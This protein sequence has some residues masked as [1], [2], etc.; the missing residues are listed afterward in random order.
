TTTTTTRPPTTTTT[1]T[2]RPPTT[3]TRPPTTTT[4]TRP[5]TTTTT[6]LVGSGGFMSGILTD[7]T[8]VLS[9]PNLPKPA[10]LVPV[11]ASPLRVPCTRDGNNV[12]LSTSPV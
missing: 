11:P 9:E 7:P 1:T 6:T 8:V 2:T 10:Y 5:P 4:T 12:G 3:T